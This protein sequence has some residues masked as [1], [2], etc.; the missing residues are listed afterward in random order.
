[1]SQL[2][3]RDGTPPPLITYRPNTHTVT[4]VSGAAATNTNPTNAYDSSTTTFGTYGYGSGVTASADI[5]YSGFPSVIP[6]NAQLV[7]RR[8][9]KASMSAIFSGTGSIDQI[10]EYSLNNGS[11]WTTLETVTANDTG[12][13]ALTD[14][15]VGDVT[16]TLPVGQNLANVKVRVN[17]SRTRAGVTPDFDIGWTTVDIYDVRIVGY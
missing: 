6:E 12:G 16:L 3:C 1:M 11:T 4:T 7:F 10:T 13:G 14:T 15:G 2:F 17:V 8:R 5:V 9:S